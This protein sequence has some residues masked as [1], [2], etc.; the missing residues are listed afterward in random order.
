MTKSKNMLANQLCIFFEKNSENKL[1]IL[2]LLLAPAPFVLGSIKLFA[3][4]N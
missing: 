1:Y 4:Y 3:P 2:Y